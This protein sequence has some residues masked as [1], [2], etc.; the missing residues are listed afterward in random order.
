[1][2]E[3]VLAAR[4]HER[5][6]QGLM[7]AYEA[8]L[9]KEPLSE[10][11]LMEKVREFAIVKLRRY[12]MRDSDFA[13]VPTANTMDDFAQDAAVRVW[14]GLKTFEGDADDFYSFVNKVSFHRR[15]DFYRELEDA[16]KHRVGIMVDR[17]NE[18]GEIESIDNPELYKSDDREYRVQIPKSIQG[19][20]LNICKLMLDGKNYSQVAKSLS[21]TEDAVK[22]RMY[23]LR[24]RMDAERAAKESRIVKRSSI[25]AD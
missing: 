4:K 7:D 25:A 14:M 1:V 24:I 12:E 9:R 13:G 20:E 10:E 3:N 15:V 11:S 5:I 8:Y 6:K 16:K 18:D 19:V 17:E 23:R 2:S 22:Q 21:M